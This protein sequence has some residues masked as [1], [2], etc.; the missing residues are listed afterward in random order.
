MDTAIRFTD[1]LPPPGTEGWPGPVSLQV[2]AG[3]FALF[4][5][6]PGTALSLIRM[7][8]GL[9]EPRSGTVEALGVEP[10]RLN[11]WDTQ[12]FRRRLG[13]GFD[14]PSGLV[15]NLTLRMN[16]VVP[17]LYS[18]LRDAALAHEMAGALIETLG[19]E[20]WAETRPADMPPEIRREA[21]LARAVVRQPD[22]LVLEEP[23][24]GIR[25]MRAGWLLSICRQHAG[26][27]VM[28]T[29]EQEGVQY[30]Q[31]DLVITLDTSGIEIQ[32]NEVGVL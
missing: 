14:E 7:I 32:E 6:T 29:A 21:V 31:A 8:V 9:R 22:L 24:S 12:Q 19:L 5:V 23:T 15:S 17:M 10:G 11:R 13:V 30:E 18:G 25:E 1:V 20:R 27:I 2:P 16:M 4:V 26:T 3:A 28:T